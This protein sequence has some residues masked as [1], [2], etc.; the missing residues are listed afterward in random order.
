MKK[1]CFLLC[2]LFL[3]FSLSACARI[4]EADAKALVD[5]LMEYIEQGDYDSA[6]A[7]FCA[8]EAD[9]KSFSEFLDEIEIETGLE[10]QS[11]IEIIEYSKY[12]S[13]PSSYWGVTCADF[14]MKAIVD[15]VEMMMYVGVLENEDAIECYQL[16]IYAE[17]NHYQFLC[18]CVD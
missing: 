6:A 17:N 2:L 16:V 11:N 9:G 7:L 5:E 15:G 10:F 13:A 12:H 3:L 18:D 4:D 8:K 1:I 14:E